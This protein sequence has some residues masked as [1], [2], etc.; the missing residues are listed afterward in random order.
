MFENQSSTTR[1]AAGGAIDTGGG[2]NVEGGTI[3]G[4]GT[5][6]KSRTDAG[7][8]T[9]RTG[10]GINAAFHYRLLSGIKAAS[11]VTDPQ[12][13]GPPHDMHVGR[14][15]RD[16]AGVQLSDSYK[17]RLNALCPYTCIRAVLS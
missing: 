12:V 6:A 2:R 8:V 15:A 7:G 5:D 17:V 4:D 3:S 10:D 1:R 14:L 13:W 16:A 11:A 9:D